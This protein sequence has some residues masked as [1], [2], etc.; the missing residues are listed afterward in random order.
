M[1]KLKRS[2]ARAAM[3]EAG[4]CKMN[5]KLPAAKGEKAQS[6]FARN[7]RRYC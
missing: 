5:K 7:W 4:Y 6:I 1:R 2:M 3:L